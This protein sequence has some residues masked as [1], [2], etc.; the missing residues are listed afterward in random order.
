[1][2]FFRKRPKIIDDTSL[3]DTAVEEQLDEEV[4]Q[5]TEQA[6]ASTKRTWFG[7][8]A[9]LFDRGGDV[10]EALWEELEE[11]LIGADVG[12]QTTQTILDHVRA[13]VDSER[14]KSAADVRTVL[15][16]ELVSLLTTP[17][18]KGRLW[19]SDGAPPPKPAVILVLGVNGTGKTTTIAKLASAYQNEGGKT[20]IAAADTFRAAAIEQLKEWG[21]R[22]GADV[23]AHKQG[24][25]P[26]AVVF[27][28]LEAAESRGADMLIIDTAGRLHTKFNLMEELR[29]LRRVIERK[30]PDAPHEV[31]LVLDA[32]T[33]QNAL[34]QAKA[35]TEAVEVTS[36][37]LTKLDGTSKGG[38]VFAVCDQLGIPVR[39][40]GTGEGSGD[41]A[42]F[43]PQAFVDALFR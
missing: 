3:A 9:G 1:M 30:E 6:L 38:I 10:D 39:F 24:A 27:D 18:G 21:A 28:A 25:D 19:E 16:E 35:F 5:A 15:K 8:I 4:E 36:I 33:G 2:R 7:Q 29:K 20:V 42:P 43:S 22:V 31:L 17:Q 40:V 26:A 34:I 37:C 11:L 12:V 14:I 23:V 41:L 32:T 13:R